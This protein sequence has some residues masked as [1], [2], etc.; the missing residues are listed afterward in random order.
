MSKINWFKGSQ[1]EYEVVEHTNDESS[2]VCGN[3]TVATLSVPEDDDYDNEDYNWEVRRLDSNA[4]LLA[5][6]YNMLKVVNR[7][8]KSPSL[9]GGD[10]WNTCLEI[11]NRIEDGDNQ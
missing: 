2:I 11:K 8:I 10:L 1:G 5:E 9:S 7:V 4:R 3:H 6:A